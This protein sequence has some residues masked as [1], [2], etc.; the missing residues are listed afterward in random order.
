M[1]PEKCRLTGG[2]TWLKI[3]KMIAIG[4]D[5]KRERELRGISLKEIADSTKINIRFLQA[6]ED[7]RLDILPEK[8]FVR[9]I[10]REYA[11][12][13]G[14]DE[15]DVLNK[16]HEALQN[17][18]HEREVK[19]RLGPGLPKNIINAVRLAA[20]GAFLI[21][22]LI[23]LFFIF[24]K[25]KS[26]PPPDKSEPEA[27]AQEQIVSP[28]EVI[29]TP[30]V[31]EKEPEELNLEFTFH[32]DTWIQIY[33][34]GEKVYSGIRLQGGKYQAKAKKEMVIDLGNAGGLS[35]TINGKP[36]IP[37]GR[38]G[39][40]EKDIRIT[41]ENF[42]QYLVVVEDSEEINSMQ[43]IPPENPRE[44]SENRGE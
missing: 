39:S 24:G 12:Y 7:D 2:G 34:D 23:G 8:F 22:V 1:P 32:Q 13:L 9:G 14:L 40:V 21:A 27:M 43:D 11:K 26:T 36:G 4:Q 5:L 28:V 37:F 10:I 29:E 3:Q 44:N 33:A 42:K 15:N 17:E 16:Y 19:K 18:K 38:P 6:L 31:E 20:L 35:Y 41:L 30:K 25:S